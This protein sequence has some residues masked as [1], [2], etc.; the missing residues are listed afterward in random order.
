[1]GGDFPQVAFAHGRLNGS[2]GL[3]HSLDLSGVSSSLLGEDACRAFAESPAFVG[4][5]I[6]GRTAH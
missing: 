2:A 4:R 1:M 5:K 6:L 3:A